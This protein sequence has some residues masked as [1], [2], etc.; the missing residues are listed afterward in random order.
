MPG[1][2]FY[3]F[4]ISISTF[5]F[6]LYILCIYYSVSLASGRDHYGLSA[7]RC[8]HTFLLDINLRLF[9]LHHTVLNSNLFAGIYLES[10]QKCTCVILLLLQLLCR[11]VIKPIIVCS[12]C[13]DS[14]NPLCISYPLLY[15]FTPS[16][17]SRSCALSFLFPRNSRVYNCYWSTFQ[18]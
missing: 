7:L 9:L 6:L 3:K 12:F 4:F 2:E 10:H 5:L 16:Q 1:P 17:N 14:S 18:F 11:T 13:S 15:P 8:T